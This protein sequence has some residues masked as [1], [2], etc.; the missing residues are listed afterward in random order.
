MSGDRS[1]E[2]DWTASGGAAKRHVLP[3][4]A[5]TFDPTNIHPLALKLRVAN[6]FVAA[7]LP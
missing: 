7:G 4:P 5:L 3:W 6:Q 2:E 1:K